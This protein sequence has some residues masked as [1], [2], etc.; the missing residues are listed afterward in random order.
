MTSCAHVTSDA[1]R[2]EPACG[3]A[4]RSRPAQAIRAAAYRLFAEQG[5]DATPVD[6]IAAEA[7]VSPSTVFRY[8]PTKEDIVLTDEYDEVMADMLRARPAA[9]RRWSRVR[10]VMHESLGGVLADPPSGPRWCS[11]RSWC[12]T[13]RR[14]GPAPT[15]ACPP[16]G[17]CWAGSSRAHRPG[18]GRAGGA[19]LHRGGVRGTA[20][21]H[22]VLGRE[23]PAEDDL[24]DILDRSLP[25]APPGPGHRGPPARTD[26]ADRRRGR[27]SRRSY[28]LIRFYGRQSCGWLL[29]DG[30]RLRRPRPVLRVRS[31]RVRSWLRSVAR[32]G[33]RR[34]AD[35]VPAD[36]GRGPPA[37]RRPLVEQRELRGALL[38]DGDHRAGR[39]AQQRGAVQLRGERVTGR[40]RPPRPRA[41]RRAPPR[42]RPGPSR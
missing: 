5:Y 35:E 9:S 23:R 21:D 7:D 33:G 26:R 22:D 8:F 40:R 27:V 19:G 25:P 20:R 32:V 13:C 12:G 42:R 1:D 17:G 6:R 18:R 4:R 36:V 29:S 24:L 39:A 38:A 34:V 31:A 10:M 41:A 14:S 30:R 11:A 16:P 15:R 28:G 3:N 2:P 37:P